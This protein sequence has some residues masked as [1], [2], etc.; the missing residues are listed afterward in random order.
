MIHRPA[1]SS[2][3]RW[4]MR[5]RC[6]QCT[7]VPVMLIWSRRSASRTAAA[8][9]EALAGPVPAAEGVVGAGCVPV[10]AECD[11]F[12]TGSGHLGNA[13][14]PQQ[15]VA[16]G[17]YRRVQKALDV[18]AHQVHEVG[19]LERV[20]AREDKQARAHVRGL[21]DQP[22]GCAGAQLP[23]MPLGLT[24]VRPGAQRR[25]QARGRSPR[26]GPQ[27]AVEIQRARPRCI[28]HGWPSLTAARWPAARRPLVTRRHA[29]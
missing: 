26:S 11:G 25:S 4:R 2:A 19:P 5:S 20:S 28:L 12:G 29:R 8:G 3:T 15:E 16:Q 13:L 27:W 6:Q 17:G 9:A 10:Q 22:L 24:V 14:A 23:W 7:R 21:L 18:P 1:P